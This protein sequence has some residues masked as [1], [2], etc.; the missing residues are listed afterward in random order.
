MLKPAVPELD[1][2]TKQR[3][4]DEVERLVAMGTDRKDARRIVWLDYQDELQQYQVV[5]AAEVSPPAETE[6]EAPAAPAEE[7][8]G[9]EP[10]PPTLSPRRFWR[11][12]DEVPLTAEWLERNR[13]ELAKVKRLVGLRSEE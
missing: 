1:A 3:L 6:I 8:P 5:P 13:A 7:I 9:P 11:A 10:P 2:A 4:A 12:A